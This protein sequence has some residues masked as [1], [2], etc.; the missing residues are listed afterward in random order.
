MQ[1][2]RIFRLQRANHSCF[3]EFAEGVGF[4]HGGQEAQSTTDLVLVHHRSSK[5]Q[6]KARR[7]NSEPLDQ[8]ASVPE[9]YPGMLFYLVRDSRRT[10]RRLS[11]MASARWS[12]RPVTGLAMVRAF[13][14][15]S[16][17][18][19]TVAALRGFRCVS[20]RCVKV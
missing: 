16:S 2:R 7:E 8:N 6:S 1:L 4:F 11:E 15:A 20:A 14:I 18:A 9:I 19:S 13:T 5:S 12:A 3:Q 10:R 17:G